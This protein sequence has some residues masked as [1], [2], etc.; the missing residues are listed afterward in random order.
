MKKNH[1]KTMKIWNL[2][3]NETPNFIDECCRA[4]AM[5]RLDG[6]GMNCGC[7]YTN[8]PIFSTLE[9][10]SRYDHS[11]GVALIVWHFTQDPKQVLAALF[12]DIASPVFAHVI[13]F[14]NGDY[15]QQ[16]ST[17]SGTEE[18]IAESPEIQHCLHRLGITTDEVSDYHRYPIADNDTPR[19][20]ADRLEYTLGN[21]V[22]YKL[23]DIETVET[24]YNTL[25]VGQNEENQPEIMFR[26]ADKALMFAELALRC[27]NL[28]T[29]DADRYAMQ[30]LAEILKACLDKG[31][32]HENDFH[33]TE[34][35]VI[36][37]IRQSDFGRNE[38]Q[39]FRQM[40]TMKLGSDSP[41]SRVIF[42]KKRHIDPYVA[43]CGRVS[44]LFPDFKAALRDYLDKDFAYPIYAAAE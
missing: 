3:S 6:I 19:L 8:F 2:Y 22:N 32:I 13:D 36:E 31:I 44:A 21:I 7:E 18:M 33:S 40:N 29:S 16:E 42:A 39:H 26:D 11:R 4:K 14:L 15:L 34:N 5:K 17:E 35:E 28:Y 27:S 23:A 41:K 30:C 12:H 43:G 38:W 20:S 1:I 24:L 25:R 9:K 37:K 10:Y